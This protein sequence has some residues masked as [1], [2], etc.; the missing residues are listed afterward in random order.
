MKS[1]CV[2]PVFLWVFFFNFSSVL[3]LI[4]GF[5]LPRYFQEFQILLLIRK[6]KTALLP[7]P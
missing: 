1:I 6:T 4:T 5:K 7:L 2:I 3:E